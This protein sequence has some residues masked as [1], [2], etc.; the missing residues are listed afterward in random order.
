MNASRTITNSF[1]DFHLLEISKTT[2]HP[3]KHGPFMVSQ[4][5]SAPGDPELRECTFVLTKRGTWMHLYIFFMMPNAMRHQV[6]V[7]DSAAEI[8]QL[9][10][11][12]VG[13]P[14]V[15]TM[16]SLP[17]LLND[18]GCNPAHDD[19]FSSALMEEVRKKH[20]KGLPPSFG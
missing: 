8:M 5:G 12:L 15:E 16:E 14:V 17:E 6:A 10:E 3:E 2:H 20:P 18:S 11:T 1:H 13:K 19:P 7:F 4:S 9:A